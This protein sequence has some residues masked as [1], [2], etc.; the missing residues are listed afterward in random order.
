MSR[1]TDEVIKELFEKLKKAEKAQVAGIKRA[2]TGYGV[3]K[4][5]IEKAAK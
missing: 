1:H 5:D 3:A 4:A 2:L